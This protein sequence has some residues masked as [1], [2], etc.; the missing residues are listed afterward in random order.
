MMYSK[1]FK[2]KKLQLISYAQLIILYKQ[3]YLLFCF[4]LGGGMV[5]PLN[6]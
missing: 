1:R 2:K 6:P 5:K 3:I 4:F